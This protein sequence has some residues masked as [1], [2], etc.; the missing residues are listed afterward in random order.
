MNMENPIFPYDEEKLKK[1]REINFGRPY[2]QCKLSVMDTIADP[3]ITFDENGIS[4][5]YYYYK[6]QEK[7]GIFH[8]E[9]GQRKL[10]EMV[11]TIKKG[12]KGLYSEI[13]I[14]NM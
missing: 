14:I 6:V 4:N 8:G 10:V 3:D 13:L 11:S 9:E 5:Y 2:Q 12:S 1:N 7:N